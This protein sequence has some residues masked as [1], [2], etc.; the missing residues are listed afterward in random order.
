LR[1]LGILTAVLAACANAVPLHAADATPKVCPAGTLGTDRVLETGTQGGAEIG[2]KSYPRTLALRDHEVVL[3]FD[4][5]PEAATTPLVLD[6]LA[7]QCVK[8]TFFLIGRN[9]QALPKLARR[10]LLEG[11]SIGHHTF[12]HPAATLRR[13]TAAAAEADIDKGFKADDL[14]VYGAAGAEP[15]VPFFRYPGFADTPEVNRWLASRNIAVFG[16]DLWA[17]DWQDMTP[18]AELALIM[19]RLER[20]KGGIVLLHDARESTAKMMPAFLAALKTHGFHI[21]HIVPGPGAA[22]TRPAPAGWTSETNRI[23]AEVFQREGMRV[24]RSA[25]RRQEPGG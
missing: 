18:Q 3:T 19:E 11:H 1:Q 8:A 14:A 24:H 4:D 9:A 21:V 7:A 6:A 12:S 2:L 23:I 17:S 5:G 15:R 13:M 20:T 16:A 25:A 22:V 10:E